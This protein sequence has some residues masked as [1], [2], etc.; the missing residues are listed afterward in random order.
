MDTNSVYL[1]CEKGDLENLKKL[2]SEEKLKRNIIFSSYYNCA[3]D[4]AYK[5][6]HFDVCKY[7]I[8]K[9]DITKEEI[10]VYKDYYL[11]TAFNREFYNDN[12]E[13]I[14]FLIEEFG[15]TEEDIAE[16]M[17]EISEERRKKILEC[18]TPLGSL[19]KSAY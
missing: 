9:F 12:L 19:T 3:F 17:T 5:G 8:L 16:Y 11:R 14:I 10:Y 4:C 13:Y 2:F 15:I 18:F 1:F 6:G 7:L